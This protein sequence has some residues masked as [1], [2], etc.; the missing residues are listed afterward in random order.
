MLVNVN[1]IRKC[2]QYLDDC[3]PHLMG[4][5]IKVVGDNVVYEATNA[6]ILLRVI[7]PRIINGTAC[8]PVGTEFILKPAKSKFS[9][10]KNLLCGEYAELE[11]IGEGRYMF[12]LRNGKDGY[13]FTDLIKEEFVYPNTDCLIPAPDDLVLPT[14]YASMNPK[15]FTIVHDIVGSDI[16]FVSSVEREDEK[17]YHEKLIWQGSFDTDSRY[18]VMLMCMN[19]CEPTT[20]YSREALGHE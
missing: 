18:I 5:H 3:R 17:P 10:P 9:W 13:L 12:E 16:P 4:I 14:K 20:A 8:M 1:A 19:H 7:S 6:Q 2:M 15:F 11:D